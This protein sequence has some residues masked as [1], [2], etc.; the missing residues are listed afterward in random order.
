LAP[1]ELSSP[2]TASP[3]YTNTPENKDN[4]LKSYFLKII[5]VWFGLVWFWF[6]E[7]GLLCV[8]LAVLN[9]LCRPG[10]PRTQKS[11]CLYLPSTGI[12]GLHHHHLAIIESF[13]ENIKN[14]LKEKQENIS[15]QEEALKEETNKSLKEKEE[16]TI[17][18]IKE[19]NK[20]VQDLKMKV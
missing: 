2:T 7:T 14:S 17:K 15:K 6:F 8:V 19:L 5:E 1:S 12:K 16:N 11:T 10:W 20:V 9:S 13:K 18:Q 4:D 3:G